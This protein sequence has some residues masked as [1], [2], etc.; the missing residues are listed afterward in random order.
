MKNNGGF[1]PG[2]VQWWNC[3]TQFLEFF[4]LKHSNSKSFGNILKFLQMYKKDHI[5]AIKIVYFRLPTCSSW[6]LNHTALISKSLL[7][8]FPNKYLTLMFRNTA[9]REF[10]AIESC[11]FIEGNFLKSGLNAV[12]LRNIWQR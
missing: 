8:N 12:L 1:R 10:M 7:W 2:P 6:V 3:T 5:F 9:V 11:I 4:F